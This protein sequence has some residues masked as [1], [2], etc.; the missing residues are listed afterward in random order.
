MINGCEGYTSACSLR[1]K[2][3]A[4]ALNNALTLNSELLDL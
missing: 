3:C 4:G 1:K 2:I